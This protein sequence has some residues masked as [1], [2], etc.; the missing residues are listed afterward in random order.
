[1]SRQACEEFGLPLRIEHRRGFVEY[2]YR[3]V[4][5]Q[6]AGEGEAL[7]LAA[8]QPHAAIADQGVVARAGWPMNSSARAATA[9]ASISPGV[10][11][12]GPP[13]GDVVAHPWR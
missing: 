1:M 6:R 9:A 7:L 12:F 13:V 8:G 3:R 5:Q 4:F 11:G 2:Q 10:A